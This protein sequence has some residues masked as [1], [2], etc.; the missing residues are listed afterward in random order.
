MVVEERRKLTEE[1]KQYARDMDMDLFGI[2]AVDVL[3][4]KSRPGRRP[5]DIFPHAQA[6]LVWGY[7]I[8]DPMSKAYIS[9]TTLHVEQMATMAAGNYHYSAE[10]R[11]RSFLRKRGF[12]GTEKD[13]C[14]GPLLNGIH[15]RYAFQQAGLG[16]VGNSGN[17]ICEKYGPRFYIGTMMT[18]APLIPDEPYT[19]NLCGNCKVCETFCMSLAILDDGYFNQRQCEAVANSTKQNI[20]YSTNGWHNC[21]MCWR[22]CP[23]GTVKF[24]K[25]ER[26]G[27][28]WDIKNRHAQTPLCQHSAIEE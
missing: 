8:L 17:A 22:M 21:D 3:N 26:T 7:G 9:S 10:A 20:Y 13:N 1:L 4:Q 12:M 14:S 15:Q 16:Y 25:E 24:A 5:K 28:W 2:A 23:V 11:F 27:S 6:I 18:D 19:K